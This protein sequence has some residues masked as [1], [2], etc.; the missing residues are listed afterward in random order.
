MTLDLKR[1]V[2]V[3]TDIANDAEADVIVY[4][5]MPFT[6]K[7]LSKITGEQNAMIKAISMCLLGIIE[8]LEGL[9]GTQ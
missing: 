8:E 2:P 6:G 3:L 1:F 9:E 7:T 5:G 4:D